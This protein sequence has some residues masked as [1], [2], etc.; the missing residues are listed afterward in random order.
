[1][2]GLRLRSKVEILNV[3][4]WVE[5]DKLAFAPGCGRCSRLVSHIA[6]VRDA[7]PGYHCAPVPAWGASNSRL[8][9]V[10]L[11][12]G[13]HGAN[14]T[15]QPFTGD[16]SGR[17]LFAAL[18]ASGFAEEVQVGRASPAA[19]PQQISLKLRNCRITNAV[20]CLPPVN[21]PLPA[22]VQRCAPYLRQEIDELWRPTMRRPRV[23]LALGQ[24]ALLAVLD[25]LEL[26]RG[27]LK[28]A[29]GAS[30][31]VAPGLKVFASYHPS[32][33][34]VN[35]GRLTLPMLVDVFDGIRDELTR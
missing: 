25:A 12:P 16:A 11:A 29:H 32:R 8:L 14:R 19:A 27:S 15:G 3:A 13:L 24:I 35:T 31:E 7:H 5:T 20:K 21:R 2:G 28:F 9:V 23:I 4:T 30:T 33:Q 26:S 10:G 1:M 17:T 34:N 18:L 6:E 22:E